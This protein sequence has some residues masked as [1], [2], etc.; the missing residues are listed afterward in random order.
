MQ[1]VMAPPV[2]VILQSKKIIIEIGP[3]SS[4]STN[5]GNKRYILHVSNS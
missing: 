2:A 5:V 1:D 3:F 4:K